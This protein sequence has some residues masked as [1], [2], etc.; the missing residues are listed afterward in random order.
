[1]HTIEILHLGVDDRGGPLPD[2]GDHQAEPAVRFLLGP[3]PDVGNG[4]DDEGRFMRRHRRG[5][6]P[7]AGGD[8]LDVGVAQLGAASR[9]NDEGLQLRSGAAQGIIAAWAERSKRAR[10]WESL[11]NPSSQQ[12]RVSKMETP[13]MKPLSKIETIAS[14]A[15]K[16]SPLMQATPFNA[17]ILIVNPP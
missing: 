6:T 16:N 14:W 15:G 12:A 5:G 10:C 9:L 13:P 7:A 3:E 17:C 8:G 11:N 4:I 2:R 1:M